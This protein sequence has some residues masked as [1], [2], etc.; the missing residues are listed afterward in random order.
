GLDQRQRRTVGPPGFRADIARKVELDIA[1]FSR[2]GVPYRGPEKIVAF[3]DQSDPLI[4][5][6]RRPRGGLQVHAL[7]HQ[8]RD[9]RT[10]PGLQRPPS[11]GWLIQIPDSSPFSS[12]NQRTVRPSGV[13]LQIVIPIWSSVTRLRTPVRLSS[14]STCQEPD[15]VDV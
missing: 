2:D 12:V 5:W 11:N 13:I 7:V 8:L 3:V 9:H 4:T 14:V 1:P 15:S 10:G 6:D